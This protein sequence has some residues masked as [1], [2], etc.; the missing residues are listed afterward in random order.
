LGLVSGEFWSGQRLVCPDPTRWGP[1]GK[2]RLAHLPG[3]RTGCAG[4]AGPPARGTRETRRCESCH[5]GLGD[6][7]R[8]RT[9]A[10]SCP[11]KSPQVATISSA[12]SSMVRSPSCR[13]LTVPDIRRG[14]ICAS[15]YVQTNSVCWL[16]F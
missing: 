12:K 9:A 10:T 13:E 8:S 1:P 15:G 14:T 16:G 2:Y 4:A 11:I 3:N 5:C 7:D 6:P